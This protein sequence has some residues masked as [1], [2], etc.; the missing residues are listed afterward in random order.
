MALLDLDGTEQPIDPMLVKAVETAFLSFSLPTVPF[1]PVPRAWKK[2]NPDGAAKGPNGPRKAEMKL[3]L[4]QR[5]GFR[6]GYCA[7][8]F[9]DLDDATLD[10]VIPNCVVGHWKTWNLVLACGPCNNVKGDNVPLVL[11]P[12]LGHLLV[13][14]ATSAQ[15]RTSKKATVTK[16]PKKF[17]PPIPTDGFP[18][19][20]AA[21]RAQKAAYRAAWT[22]KQV[23]QALDAMAAPPI[24]P[25][26]E[27]A[28]VRAALTSG[29]DGE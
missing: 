22:R 18:S 23:D 19:R 11:M 20:A 1:L 16:A 7:R 26:L 8:E 21:R 4:I 24:R 5:D 15:Y 9:V 14:M 6:C 29:Q 25:A 17:T 28:P 10:H 3:E 12:M 2:S 27:S 13:Q